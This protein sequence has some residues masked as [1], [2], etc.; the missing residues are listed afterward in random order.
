M[1]QIGKSC[2]PKIQRAVSMVE[3]ASSHYQKC[4]W[5]RLLNARHC[6]LETERNYLLVNARCFVQTARLFALVLHIGTEIIYNFSEV[7]WAFFTLNFIVL[8]CR[9]TNAKSPHV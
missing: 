7:L 8:Y 1:R 3:M 2:R 6:T 5:M 4:S 9:L